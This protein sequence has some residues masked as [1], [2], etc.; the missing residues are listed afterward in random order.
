MGEED[1]ILPGGRSGVLN[2]ETLLA[3]GVLG[4]VRVACS[5]FELRRLMILVASQ[6]PVIM[7]SNA[8][9]AVL[10][11]IPA[12]PRILSMLLFTALY[13]SRM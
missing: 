13:R 1:C 5:R 11:S 6:R 10:A 4:G 2:G 8:Y 7:T 3:L 12:W 9:R